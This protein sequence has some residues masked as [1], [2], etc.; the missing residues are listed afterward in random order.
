MNNIYIDPSYDMWKHKSILSDCLYDL[1]FKNLARQIHTVEYNQDIIEEYVTL[2]KT[3][4]Q[5]S[6]DND[7]IDRLCFAGLIYG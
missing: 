4:S 2:A 5:I 3:L 1:G 7:V 6:N